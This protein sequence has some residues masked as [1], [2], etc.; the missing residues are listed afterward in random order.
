MAYYREMQQALIKLAT[1]FPIL[2]ITGPRQSGK[3][4]L[5]RQFFPDKPYF[6]LEDPSLREQINQDP[7]GLLASLG[8]R[9][10]IFDEVQ[11]LPILLSY[12][13]VFVDEQSSKQSIKGQFVL[14][15]SYNL[16]LLESVTQSL[17]GRVGLLELL[18][19]STDELSRAEI[20]LTPEQSLLFG[21]LPRVFSENI[22]PT[23]VYQ[24]YVKTYVERDVRSLLNIKDLSQFQRFL[25]LCAGRIGSEFVASHLAND[26]GVSYHTVQSWVSVLEASY[27]IFRLPP[28]FENLGKRVI[29]SPKLYFC[30]VGLACY[31]LGLETEHQINRDPLKGNLFENLV[32][33]DLYK[34]CLNLGREPRLVFYRDQGQHEVD[35]IWQQGRELT[36]I[37][38]K[39]GQT[40]QASFTKGLT[41]FKSIAGERVPQG[42]VVYTG[43]TLAAPIGLWSIVNYR[44][45]AQEIVCGSA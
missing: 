12:L 35:L 42:Y 10:A 27:L 7:K 2:C 45:S 41:Y 43:E 36:P 6:N 3:T 9:G 44:Q 15:G 11:N 31:L 28:Y 25:T 19:M 34:K 4:T 33:L 17:A 39:F 26:L 13:Q 16:G 37:E 5:T 24:N 8:S 29:K 23:L 21:G 38:I 1:S 32:V 20:S 40:F 18:P 30:D 14:T 22:P